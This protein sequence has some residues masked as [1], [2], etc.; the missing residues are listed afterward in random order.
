M[1]EVILLPEAET[2]LDQACAWYEGQQAGLADQL[3]DNVRAC[4][5][6]IGSTPLMH[7]IV[8][9]PF[10]RGIVKRFPYSIFYEVRDDIV[11]VHSIFQNSQD[12]E[13]WRKRLP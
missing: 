4:L 5:Q 10:R 7:R 13:K 9:A 2:D 1:A 11:Y 8:E 3:L 12:P 6:A